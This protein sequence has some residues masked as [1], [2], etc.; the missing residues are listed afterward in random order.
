MTPPARLL[1]AVRSLDAVAVWSGKIVAWM[2]I[3]MVLSLVYEVVARYVFDAPTTWAYDMTFM[4]YGSFFMLGAAYTLQKGGH[5]R[6]DNFYGGWSVRRQ[7]WT[8]VACYLVLFFP[9][10]LIFTDLSW[11]Y[12]LRSWGQSERIVTSPWMPPVYPF[13]ATMPAAGLLLLL[14][15]VSEFLKSLWAG[16]S[17]EKL[18]TGA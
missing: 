12:F 5:I 15:G 6:T 7:G 9:A 3:P 8:D 2:I 18:E 1:F 17:G 4:L 14:Q 10:I 16:I 13:K 11:D